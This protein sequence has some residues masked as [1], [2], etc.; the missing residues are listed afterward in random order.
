MNK[1]Q[2]IAP[3]AF[4][5]ALE[6]LNSFIDERIENEV[7]FK[8]DQLI[9]CSWMWFKVGVK[10]NDLCVLAPEFGVNP[11]NFI[12]DCS[13]SLNIVLTQKYLVESFDADFGWCDLRQSALVLKGFDD[14]NDQFMSR[15][16]DVDG[17][18]SGWYFGTSDNEIDANNPD[19]LELK[20]L[21]EVFCTHPH[22]GDFLLL[23]S[24][25]QVFFEDVPVVL[26]DYEKARCKKDS[27]YQEAYLIR[28]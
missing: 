5:P 26:N 24:G 18:S 25:W 21:W 20:S 12:N 16:D 10:E 28:D 7:P 1:P 4:E 23:P 11:M 19:N 22:I 6:M 9:Q 14:S 8:P 17:Y 27:Y 3:N 13:D 2:I 15:L